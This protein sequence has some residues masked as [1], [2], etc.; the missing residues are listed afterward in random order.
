MLTAKEFLP[1]AI[2]IAGFAQFSV[3]IASAYVPAHLEW[4]KTFAVLP[5]LHRQLIWCYAAFIAASIIALGLVC[6]TNST[7]LASGDSLAR[8]ICIYGATFWGIRLLLQAVFDV[9]PYLTHWWL[10]LG[11]HALTVWF[12][13]FVAVYVWGAVN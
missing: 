1:W 4:R 7:Q 3:L 8:A 12:I 6:V 9:R 10:R 2:F 5:R 11:Y 13:G